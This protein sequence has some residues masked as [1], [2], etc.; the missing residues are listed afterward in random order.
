M[1][2]IIVLV[3]LPF[4]ILYH[5]QEMAVTEYPYFPDYEGWGDFFLYGKSVVTIVAAV[6]SLVLI[7][8]YKF[9]QGKK[10]KVSKIW[11]A[12][13]I[14]EVACV[15]SFVFSIDKSVSSTGFFDQ[16]ENIWVCL[17]YGFLCFYGFFL[18]DKIP[19]QNILRILLVPAFALSVLGL[20]QFLSHDMI[21]ASGV[22]NMLVPDS[23][24]GQ[25]TYDFAEEQIKKVYLTFYNPNYAAVYL[26]FVLP[27]LML[28]LY[29]DENKIWKGLYG[30]TSV[31]FFICLIGTGSKAGILVCII[32][33]LIISTSTLANQMKN[34]KNNLLMITATVPVIF[35]LCFFCYKF[36]DLNGGRFN[37]NL[38]EGLQQVTVYDDKIGIRFRDTEMYFWEK[39]IPKENRVGVYVSDDKGRLYSYTYSAEEN[40][41]IL[42]EKKFSNFYFGCF[43]KND[44]S[45]LFF[46]YNDIN[47][48]FTKDTPQGIYSYISTYGKLENIESAEK[49]YSTKFDGLFTYRGYIWNRTIPLLKKYLLWGSGQ[50]TYGIVFPQNNYVDRSKA[51]SGFF[52]E[53]LTKPHNMYLQ[54]A[55]QTG[56]VSCMA[57]L[58][59]WGL[60]MKMLFQQLHKACK[61]NNVFN[62]KILMTFIIA[63]MAYCILGMT[64]DSCVAVAPIFWLLSGLGI[65]MTMSENK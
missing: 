9:V 53:T 64:N 20:S 30:V 22:L 25:I 1:P 29:I 51:G 40:A 5:M 39:D 43:E 17:A 3:V 16:Y 15:V 50:N 26:D 41:L 28:G 46:R 4:T 14:F 44:I 32:E 55:V 65:G 61:E 47:W 57:L 6:L 21:Q 49:I 59:F 54:T 23:F 33:M 8:D 27:F 18:Y 48:M 45:Y 42:D 10:I 63:I 37:G 60:Y 56:V 52:Y 7:F 12:M 34:N 24:Q 19:F 13:L 31:G 36:F 62:I 2:A 58:V 35:I 38:E 11:I